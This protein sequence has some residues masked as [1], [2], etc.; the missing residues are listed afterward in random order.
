MLIDSPFP[1][2][3]I[4]VRT[5]RR[6]IFFIPLNS[7]IFSI[8]FSTFSVSNFS[9]ASFTLFMYSYNSFQTLLLTTSLALVSSSSCCASIASHF[10]LMLSMFFSISSNLLSIESLDTYSSPSF[11]KPSSF[12][13]SLMYS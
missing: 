2:T 8:I 9:L 1:A 5:H 10:A 6:K 3:P 13:K 12:A 7:L 11:T 4:T